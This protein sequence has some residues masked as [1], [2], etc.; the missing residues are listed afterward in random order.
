MSK[1]VSRESDPL[2]ASLS[3]AIPD[4]S[5]PWNWA[6][7]WGSETSDLPGP[8]RLSSGEV[9]F[10]PNHPQL[11]LCEHALD[12]GIARS[13]PLAQIGPRVK[14]RID[15][16]AQTFDERVQRRHDVGIRQLVRND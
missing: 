2:R 4:R 11:G 13:S 7:S 9:I 16:A 5:S 10:A 8:A 15:L 12:E 3:R 14:G 6:S 1:R